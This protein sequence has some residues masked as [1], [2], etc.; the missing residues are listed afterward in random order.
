VQ[1]FW[2]VIVRDRLDD[3]ERSEAQKPDRAGDYA[4]LLE[5]F[6]QANALLVDALENSDDDV[7]VWTWFDGDHSVGFV[8][9]RQAHEALIHRLDAEGIR[10]VGTDLDPVLATD[11][12]LE[13]LEWMYAGVPEWA[14]RA[15][16]GAIGR[17][18]TTDTGGDWLVRLGHWSGH[19]PNTGRTYEREPIITVVEDGRPSF[20]IRG[21][22]ADLDR[23]LWNRPTE[24]EIVLE[25][26]DAAEFVAVIRTGVQ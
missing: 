16:D 5:Q 17:V 14:T 13:V 18:A 3:P 4:G 20:E 10:N 23:W 9:R 8:R 24:G 22:A 21:P 26:E 11:G 19:S 15:D 6:D 25:G 12:V 7:P 2:G 1:H